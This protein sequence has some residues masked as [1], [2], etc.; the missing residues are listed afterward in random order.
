LGEW[1]DVAEDVF[2]VAE[3]SVSGKCK[4][5]DA[6]KEVNMEFFFTG[7]WAFMSWLQS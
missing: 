7:K 3:N 5:A 2:N 4:P 1:F 6:G